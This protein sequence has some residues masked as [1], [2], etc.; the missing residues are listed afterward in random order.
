MKAIKCLCDFQW[1]GI[2]KFH[3]FKDINKF[4][5]YKQDYDEVDHN[6]RG[7]ILDTEN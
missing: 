6:I 2:D 4:I 3:E 5:F 7:I 1:F